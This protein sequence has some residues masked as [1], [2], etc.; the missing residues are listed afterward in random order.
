MDEFK[1]IFYMEY[2][3]RILGR[4]IGVAF[5]LP[6]VYLLVSKR[7]TQTL[8]VKLGALAG[9]IGVQGFLG[10]YMVKSGL[11]NSLMDTPGAVPRV[12]QYRLAAHLGAALALYAGM[13][14]MGLAVLR[15]WK[16][17]KEGLW[18]GL[19]DDKWQT[20]LKDVRIQQFAGRAWVLTGLVFLTALS[21]EHQ[22]R[23]PFKHF[24][25]RFPR[26]FCC[27]SRCRVDVQRVPHDG[28]TPRPAQG[29]SFVTSI[30]KAC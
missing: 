23:T 15:D 25:K 6:Y 3:H 13:L 26:C 28:G 30:R 9:L 1:R 8:P 22:F 21:G 19:Q 27:R 18:S 16:Y 2:S 4:L 17:A 11:E 14:R 5:V 12:S 24:A 10:W 7:L 20:L 29:R